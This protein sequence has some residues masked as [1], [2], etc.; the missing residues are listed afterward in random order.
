MSLYGA[1][2]YGAGTYGIK[3]L[4]MSFNP[5]R[6]ELLISKSSSLTYVL[7]EFGLTAISAQIDDV[8]YR[9]DELI[10]HSPAVIVQDNITFSTDII[11]FNTR[12]L[13]ALEWINL[14]VDC[15]DDIFVNV[16]YRDEKSDA[17][18]SSSRKQFN[19][20]GV[21]RIGVRGIDF[22]LDFDIPS[23]TTLQLESM[24]LSVQFVDRRFRRGIAGDN[25]Q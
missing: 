20:E 6:D 22:I 18:V 3:G 12:G 8:A 25:I 15:P 14:N 4:R 5:I 13:K 10:V 2:F 9:Y 17:F 1:G 24:D 16:R 7:S 23:Y 19:A 21:C 11:N